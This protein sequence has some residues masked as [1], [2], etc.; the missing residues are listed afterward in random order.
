MADR[1]HPGCPAVWP[2]GLAPRSWAT[3]PPCETLNAPRYFG[4]VD[5][6]RLAPL[7]QRHFA[8]GDGS[9]GE[10]ASD[11]RYYRCSWARCLLKGVDASP[12]LRGGA[13]GHLPGHRQSN[14]RAESMSL[15][16]ALQR[17]SGEME[18]GFWTDRDIMLQ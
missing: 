15:L 16:S 2:T 9:A 6:S 14:T 1:G 18:M 10:E 8:C 5:G 3:P 13:A 7:G 12:V 4:E 17:T 11:A